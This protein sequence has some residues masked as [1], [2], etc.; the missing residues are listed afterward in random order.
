MEVKKT[1][2]YYD[3]YYVCVLI[4]ENNNYYW[5]E[6]ESGYCNNSIK[7]DLE[8]HYYDLARTMI[9]RLFYFNFSEDDL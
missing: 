9:G 7:Y 6:I 5:K 8:K 3:V 1:I 4:K 2:K